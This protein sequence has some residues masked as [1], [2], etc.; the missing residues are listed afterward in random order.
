MQYD[1]VEIQA[2]IYVMDSSMVLHN[3][4]ICSEPAYVL[5]NN[6][7]Y[8]S[9]PLRYIQNVLY[10]GLLKDTVILLHHLFF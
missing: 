3:G 7:A 5:Y 10:L 9:R 8:Q 1:I 2:F 4:G 6:N